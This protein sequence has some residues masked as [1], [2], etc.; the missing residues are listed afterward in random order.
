[1]EAKMTTISSPVTIGQQNRVQTEFK[2]GLDDFTKDLMVRQKEWL[3]KELAHNPYEQ[4]AAQNAQEVHTAFR[5]NGKLVGTI[6]ENGG[7]TATG[8]SDGGAS[9]AAVAY[10][11]KTGLKGA[12]YAD[13]LSQKLSQ[14]F[15]ERYGASVEVVTY[16]TGDRPTVGEMHSEMFGGVLPQFE[17]MSSDRMAYIRHFAQSYAQVFGEDP[18]AGLGTPYD[19]L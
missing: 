6:D 1:M 18:F 2:S 17:A 9:Q 16:E 13:Y 19:D 10:A 12:A 14:V 8:I 7:F 5:M 11:E 15:K 4:V 3:A